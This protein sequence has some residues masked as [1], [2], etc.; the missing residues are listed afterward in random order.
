MIYVVIN[1]TYEIPLVSTFNPINFQYEL[2][3]KRLHKYSGVFELKD[4]FGKLPTKDIKSIYFKKDNEISYKISKLEVQNASQRDGFFDIK[5][6]V[7]NI[8]DLAEKWLIFFNKVGE[9]SHNLYSNFATSSKCNLECEYCVTK[10]QDKTLKHTKSNFLL[11][12]HF[13]RKFEKIMSDNLIINRKIVRIMGGETFLD[14]KDFDR[15]YKYAVDVVGKVNR[16]WIYSN[17]TVNYDKWLDYACNLLDNNEIDRLVNVITT[18]SFDC[19]KSMRIHNPK[20]ME[21]HIENVK[22]AAERLKK[23]GSDKAWISS[24]LMLIDYDETKKT[25]NFLRDCGFKYFQ[26]A[27]DETEES[28]N[29]LESNLKLVSK[30]H[31]ELRGKVMDRLKEDLGSYMWFHFDINDGDHNIYRQKAIFNVGYEIARYNSY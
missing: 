23:Y 22:M 7:D 20:L 4:I 10:S 16:L 1:D 11:A 9:Y 21:K 27:F 14:M 2:T 8:F 17:A 6:I 29:I 15:T 18:D 26:I 13:I 25:A 19:N 30:L 28:F 5:I 12:D 3:D 24:L 31:K